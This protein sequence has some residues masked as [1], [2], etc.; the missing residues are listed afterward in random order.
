[1]ETEMENSPQNP[2]REFQDYFDRAR[3]ELFPKMAGS[4]FCLSIVGTPDPKLCMEIGAAIL[5]N[6]P[7]MLVIPR[8]RTIPLS[9]RTIAHEIVEID[10]MEDAASKD[11]ITAAVKRMIEVARFR[12]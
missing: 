11:R 8:G 4:A 9:L 6:K 1:M 7:I 5:F 3:R 2:D 10:G 12:G